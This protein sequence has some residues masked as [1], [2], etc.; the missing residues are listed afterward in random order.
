MAPRRTIKPELP[1]SEPEIIP[2]PRSRTQ[3]Y[4]AGPEWFAGQRSSSSRVF[5]ARL[6][7]TWGIIGIVLVFGLIVGAV[8]A[9]LLGALLIAIPVI[10]LLVAGALIANALRTRFGRPR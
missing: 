8:L 3:A 6:G 4:Q 9:I 1:R 5:V 10:G 2:P 7:P